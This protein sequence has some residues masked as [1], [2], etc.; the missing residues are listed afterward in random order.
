MEV[1][2]VGVEPLACMTSVSPISERSKTMAASEKRAEEVN[3]I[4][5]IQSII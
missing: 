4:W 5:S 2:R 1:T 3:E